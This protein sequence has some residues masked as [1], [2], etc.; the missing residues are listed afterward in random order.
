MIPNWDMKEE[1]FVKFDYIGI[2]NL[3][4]VKEN[5]NPRINYSWEEIFVNI[6]EET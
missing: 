3:C 6:S 2:L 1:K 5:N 4:P